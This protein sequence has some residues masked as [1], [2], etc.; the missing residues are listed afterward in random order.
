M[1]MLLILELHIGT[2][3]SKNNSDFYKIYKF[4]SKIPFYLIPTI[5][6]LGV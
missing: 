4:F 2:V 3:V 5:A 6:V 1:Q